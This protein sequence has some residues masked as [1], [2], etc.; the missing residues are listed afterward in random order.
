MLFDV[1]VYW[2]NSRILV[3][4]IKRRRHFFAYFVK[5]QNFKQTRHELSGIPFGGGVMMDK[6]LNQLE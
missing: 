2:T 5:F 1:F 3:N 6:P 4:I